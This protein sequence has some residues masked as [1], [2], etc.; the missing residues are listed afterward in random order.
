MTTLAAIRTHRWGDDE[1][2]LQAALQPVFGDRLAVVFHNR[3]ASVTVPIDVVDISD[4]WLRQ[5]GL[6][7]LPDWGWRCGDYFYYALRAARPDYERYWLI[8][9]DVLFRGDPAA[10]FALA[11]R[12][13]SD[14]LGARLGE[15]SFR[16]MFV[17][18][19]TDRPPFQAIFPVTRLSGRAIDWLLPERR[20]YSASRIRNRLFTN[21]EMF[22]F[23][24]L[25]S[26]PDFSAQALEHVVPG[27]LDG[28]H[29][30][31]DPDILM[32]AALDP[33]RPDGLYHPVRESESYGREIG[34]K[35][36]AVRLIRRLL[37][38]SLGH[39][40]DADAD[41]IAASVAQEFRTL[42]AAAR[43][44]RVSEDAD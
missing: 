26:N 9:P 42:F 33:S 15:P 6:R 17:P 43:A 21:D 16:H 34:R 19:V 23:S 22:V 13:P 8:E 18:G 5:Q 39:L 38:P 2:R 4:D 28:T 36:A 31:T 3:P 37:E 25:G 27:W 40:K 44:G 24:W 10:F 14:A 20:K 41:R 1:V 12:D 35:I 32:D 7:V 11:E 29:F 30:V